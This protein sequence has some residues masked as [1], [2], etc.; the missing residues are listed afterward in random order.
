[1]IKTGRLIDLPKYKYEEYLK[2]A[3]VTNSTF[4][5]KKNAKNEDIYVF[6]LKQ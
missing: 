5:L 2:L 3:T 6:H 1:M 4:N